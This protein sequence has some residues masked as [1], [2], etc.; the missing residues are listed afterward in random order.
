MQAKTA[1][2]LKHTAPRS[3]KMLTEKLEIDID[4]LIRAWLQVS[5]KTELWVVFVEKSTVSAVLRNF[6]VFVSLANTENQFGASLDL[7]DRYY[8]ELQLIVD[9][10]DQFFM[11]TIPVSSGVERIALD[12]LSEVLKVLLNPY[13]TKHEKVHLMATIQQLFLK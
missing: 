4:N 9:L 1:Q 7:T 10:W 2:D 12:V 6:G 8:Q 5:E 3:T 11:T 13:M